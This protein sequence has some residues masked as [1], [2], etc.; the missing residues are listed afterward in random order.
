MRAARRI[1]IRAEVSGCVVMQEAR[2]VCSVQYAAHG[3]DGSALGGARVSGGCSAAVGGGVA[4]A[5]AVLFSLGCRLPEPGSWHCH[6]R[7]AA[8]HSAR[9]PAQLWQRAGGVRHNPSRTIINVRRHRRKIY[10]LV[11]TRIIKLE[12]MRRL[13]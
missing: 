3:G 4:E 12:H 8:R 5:V 10:T 9:V 11:L 1:R 2:S 13:P 7:S 6:A